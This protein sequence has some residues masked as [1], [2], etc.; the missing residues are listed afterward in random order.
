[1]GVSETEKKSS[2]SQKKSQSG[3]GSYLIQLA[4]IK[5]LKTINVVR[6]ESAIDGVIALG[7][8]AALVDS[9]D[10]A[11]DVAKITGD[12]LPKLAIDAIGGTLAN[13]GLKS[14]ELCQVS[15][16]SLVF[17]EVTVKGFWLARWFRTATPEQQ[18][19]V[20]GQI[21]KYIV[22]GKLQNKIHAEYPVSDIKRAVAAAAEGGRDGKV[23]VVG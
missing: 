16:M 6:R 3:V 9:P 15:A 5:G 22:E 11:K 18:M 10:L 7:G 1:V 13:Y 23:L 2:T 14:G 8:D 21:T 4:K 17:R 20:F 12:K 19:A